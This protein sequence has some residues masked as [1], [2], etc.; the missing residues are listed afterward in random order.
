MIGSLVSPTTCQKQIRKVKK[1]AQIRTAPIRKQ[2]ACT[3]TQLGMWDAGIPEYLIQAL[4]ASLPNQLPVNGHPGR[5]APVLRGPLR[6]LRQ[7]FSF[8]TLSW[9]SSRYYGHLERDPADGKS[10]SP[11]TSKP[12]SSSC[13][14]N[15]MKI[16][17]V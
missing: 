14:S 4:T 15:T 9:P 12:A 8:L 1:K 10:V 6:C 2:E 3:D 16:A 7:I 13:L 17:H 5:Q 11:Y